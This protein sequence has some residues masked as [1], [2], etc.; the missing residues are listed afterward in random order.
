MRRPL[1]FKGLSEGD[2]VEIIYERSLPPF[3][4]Q[5]GT[6]RSYAWRH[7]V[8]AVEFD[9][10]II[11]YLFADTYRKLNALEVLAEIE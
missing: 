7:Q 1:K 8:L 3:K 5:R 2:R 6:V 11:G 9:G 4:G 10:G